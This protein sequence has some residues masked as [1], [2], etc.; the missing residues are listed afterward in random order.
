MEIDEEERLQEEVQAKDVEEKIEQ[1]IKKLKTSA[2]ISTG[3]EWVQ[4]GTDEQ[5]GNKD[6]VSKD[7]SA[8]VWEVKRPSFTTVAKRA[9]FISTSRDPSYGVTIPDYRKPEL[10]EING[11]MPHRMS[12]NDIRNNALKL[13]EGKDT[14]SDFIRWTDRF[15]TAGKEKID[16]R[17]KEQ[18]SK[19][20]DG[21][22]KQLIA[23]MEKSQQQF[24]TARD[25]FASSPTNKSE[26]E[27]FIKQA[28]SFHAN[29]PDVGP[30]FGVNNPVQ[31]NAHMHV[32]TVSEPQPDT[33]AMGDAKDDKSPSQPKLTR[34]LSIM[35]SQVRRMSIGR[36]SAFPYTSEGKL[37]TTDGS[38]VSLDDLPK[39][40]RE[41][42]EKHKKKT[43]NGYD[44]DFKFGKADGKDTGNSQ[45]ALLRK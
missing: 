1:P 8:P 3:S 19:E 10:T 32:E 33:S 26:F 6:E 20:S 11:A 29:V 28:N 39:E 34:R 4:L 45:D 35:S 13:K 14:A 7:V 30:H 42:I 17:K 24:I 9:A 23:D 12:Y 15:I 43:V 38:T 25:K 41:A 21:Q 2:D 16:L 5:A 37:I 40:D 27:A 18:I 36:I 31:E 44:P 22:L